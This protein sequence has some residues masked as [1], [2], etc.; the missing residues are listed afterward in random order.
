MQNQILPI[1]DF[2]EISAGFGQSKGIRDLR[3]EHIHVR[4]M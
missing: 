3:S 1:R 4:H 2:Y